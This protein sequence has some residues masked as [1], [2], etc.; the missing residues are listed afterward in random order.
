[1]HY[2]GGICL[3]EIP[4]C[5][6]QGQGR[7][8]IRVSRRQCHRQ[9]AAHAVAEQRDR[10]AVQRNGDVERRLQSSDHDGTEIQVGFGL[11]PVEQHGSQAPSREVA[12]Q[13][14]AARQVEH[15]GTVDQGTDA[16]YHR[17]VTAIV[18]QARRPVAPYLGRIGSVA[19]IGMGAVPGDAA[20]HRVLPGCRL[21]DQGA[22]E[23]VRVGVFEAW[24]Q[25][26]GGV[27]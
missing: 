7:D 19:S 16:Q 21:G 24:P 27:A 25:R 20:H 8:G 17:P 15:I 1:M 3:V 12:Q 13:A 22:G 10:P 26:A 11:A 9:G 2:A 23:P 5:A 18:E 14:A 6:E 4:R